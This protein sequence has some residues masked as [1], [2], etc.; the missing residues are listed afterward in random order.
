M[1]LAHL[2][3]GYILA[4]GMRQHWGPTFAAIMVGSVFPDLD[5]VWFHLVDH[6]AI[7]HHR[8]WV[9]APGF[10]AL[11]GAVV[12]PLMALTKRPLLPAI[13]FLAS[14]LIHLILDSVGGGIMWLW[15]FSTDLFA[16][17]EVPATQSHWVLSFLLHWSFVAEL[18]LITTAATL[19]LRRKKA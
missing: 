5:M 14:V 7:H 13:G 10:W 6:G 8:Y 15:P 19:F 3:A 17:I 12:L 4:R 1:I 16:L 2:P 11:L 18:A 9:H